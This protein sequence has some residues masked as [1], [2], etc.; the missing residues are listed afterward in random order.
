MAS[1]L[2]DSIVLWQRWLTDERLK[3]WNDLRQAKGLPVESRDELAKVLLDAGA[4]DRDL[5]KG[6]IGV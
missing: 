1:N 2:A 5:I 3:R 6:W 4:E